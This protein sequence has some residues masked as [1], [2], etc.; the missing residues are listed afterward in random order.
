MWILGCF[1]SHMWIGPCLEKFWVFR[2]EEPW[3]NMWDIT[4][5]RPGNG[6]QAVPAPWQECNRSFLFPIWLTVLWYFFS[7]KCS[8]IKP[9]R[10]VIHVYIVS[11]NIKIQGDIM[12]LEELMWQLSPQGQCAH[13]SQEIGKWDVADKQPQCEWN[14]RGLGSRCHQ[15]I[16]GLLTVNI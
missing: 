9:Y 5:Q 2:R 11:W 6:V 10:K 1:M 12:M 14:S 13:S 4:C 8:C 16:S 3:Q 15:I 7:Y